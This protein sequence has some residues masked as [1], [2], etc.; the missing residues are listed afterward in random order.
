MTG[1]FTWFDLSTTD[2]PASIAFYSKLMGWGTQTWGGETPYA[3]FTRDGQ[4]FGGVMT[5]ADDAKKMGVPPNWM[6]YVAVADVDAACAKCGELGGRVYVPGTDIPDTGRFAILADPTGGVIAVF[7]RE[8]EADRPKSVA[9]CELASL[10][11]D[12]SWRFLEGMFGWKKAESMEMPGGGVYQMIANEGGSF[13]GMSKAQPGM[14]M[15][16]WAF[17]FGCMDCR[18]TF[19][20]AK[21]MGCR[22]LYAPMEVPGGGWAALLT[23]P[24]GAAFGLFSME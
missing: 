8:K 24:Q 17:Y 19:E 18:G 13:A 2:I 16:A 3:M 6:G 4:G 9:W 12:A 22:E 10:D 14:P 15:T 20:R 21:G 7:S 1:E 23:D 5:L 11:P